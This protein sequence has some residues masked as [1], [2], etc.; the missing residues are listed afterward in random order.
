MQMMFDV[1]RDRAESL[2]EALEA[3]GALSVALED[4]QHVPLY[5]P[6]PGS[7]TLWPITRLKALF[8]ECVDPS[9]VLSALESSLEA[10]PPSPSAVEQVEERDWQRECEARFSPR[11]FGGRLWVGPSWQLPPRDHREYVVLDPGLAFGTGGHPTT[12]LCLEWL[13]GRSL[14]GT[15]VV[16]YG[17]GSGILSVAAA[18]LGAQQVWGVDHDPQ[19]LQATSQNAGLNE[20]SH[21][22]RAVLPED[23]PRLQ[24][25]LVVANIL[26]TP[27]VEL[28]PKLAALLRSGSR[29]AL[30]GILE[31][32]ARQ[33]REAY[34]PWV[35]FG[36]VRVR[37]GWALLGG[38]R[39]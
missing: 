30:S 17:C 27:L 7:I 31:G 25:D 8:E 9:E 14:A 33:V 15:T 26:A 18:R 29:M 22:V 23:L 4:A 2:A 12:A 19:A 28:A 35:R 34:E 13:A 39:R 5:E 3:A 1:P 16:D 38:V 32:Q 21:R 10:C 11:L 36:E 20:L 6:A 37:E 24:G